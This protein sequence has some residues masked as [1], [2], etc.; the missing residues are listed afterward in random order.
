MTSECGISLL[1]AKLKCDFE[2]GDG[3]ALV[4]CL[5]GIPLAIVHAAA[6]IQA[7]YPRFTVPKYNKIL[8]SSESSLAMYLNKDLGDLRQHDRASSSVFKSWQVTFTQIRAERPSA[9][10]LLAALAL[11][12]HQS[13][14]EKLLRTMV[15]SSDE[16]T[17]EDNDA[18]EEDI[19]T[20]KKFCLLDVQVRHESASAF[21]LHRLVQVAT[22][23]WLQ[24]DKSLEKWVQRFIELLEREQPEKQLSG[25]FQHKYNTLLPHMR[26]L[27]LVRP[28]NT[29]YLLRWANLLVNAG[30]YLSHMGR[31][32]DAEELL[33]PALSVKSEKEGESHPSRLDCA[34]L[35]ISCLSQRGEY[36]RA[37]ELARE[38]WSQC[39]TEVGEHDERTTNAVEQLASVLRQ[40][41]NFLEAERA[42]CEALRARQETLGQEDLSVITTLDALSELYHAWGKY[43]DAEQAVRGAL[44]LHCRSNATGGIATLPRLDNLALVLHRQGKHDAAAKIDDEATQLRN[45]VLKPEAL[46]IATDWSSQISQMVA[47]NTSDVIDDTKVNLIIRG[48]ALLEQSGG[49]PQLSDLMPV[50]ISAFNRGN[51]NLSIDMLLR[52]VTRAESAYG[53]EHPHTLSRLRDLSI[54]LCLCGRLSEADGFIRLVIARQESALGPDHPDTFESWAGLA[55]ILQLRG[56]ASP[57][58]EASRH[59]LTGRLRSLGEDHPTIL[60]Y[61]ANLALILRDQGRLDESE[62]L[63]RRVVFLSEDVLGHKHELT[64]A[65]LNNLATIF[66][67]QERYEAAE[68]ILQ[69]V[70]RCQEDVMGRLHPDTL[71]STENLANVLQWQ[72][73]SDEAEDT[74]RR[75]LAG[76]KERLGITH[77][78]TLSCINTLAAIL[79]SKGHL[80]E[81]EELH[82]G[83]IEPLQHSLGPHHPQVL[84]HMTNLLLVMMKRNAFDQADALITKIVVSAQ[85]EQMRRQLPCLQMMAT[86]AACLCLQGQRERAALVME[87]VIHGY[88]ESISKGQEFKLEALRQ[89]ARFFYGQKH[90][91]VAERAQRTVLAW[92]E[93]ISGSNHEVTL[94]V[95]Q[96][97]VVI[98]SQTEKL[99][100]A[101]S[102][103]RQALVG[104]EAARGSVVNEECHESLLQLA[105][106]FIARSEWGEVEVTLPKLLHVNQALYGSTDLSTLQAMSDM[107]M[108]LHIQTERPAESAQYLRAATDGFEQA[109]GP[110]DARTEACRRTLTMMLAAQ[111]EDLERG[112][113]HGD[114]Q[115]EEEQL[116]AEDAP[117]RRAGSKDIRV[118]SVG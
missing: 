51:Y 46:F 38:I 6:L 106:L 4:E 114:P 2:D 103:S 31:A 82:R 44:K 45:E 97:L 67:S 40:E 16:P 71:K 14:S 58:E 35:L 81:A 84:A 28:S 112:H 5:D 60:K 64:L 77:P 110:D 74:I 94:K 9:S 65:A 33:S 99:E 21:S 113:G 68:E 85:D 34:S 20:L 49:G 29:D 32:A 7:R 62:L 18:Y 73:K 100:E 66:A 72:G 56:Q 27:F 15:Q 75:A 98:L 39:S 10:E 92:Y 3:R 59:A 50:A 8:R 118:E 25:M 42:Y 109:L 37:E 101:V 63:A 69:R 87:N 47:A 80:K 102:L 86:C 23:N 78:S 88:S 13:I 90:I 115:D 30:G 76:S 108:I 95:M 79:G 57:A 41:G 107:A 96:E 89:A 11:F 26:S 61:T 24:S 54:S 17:S 53:L 43:S 48:Q 1:R 52:S 105:K 70:H 83:A 55:A 117:S 36:E 91:T 116:Q 22:K 93:Q 19:S 12:D 104:F 111:E